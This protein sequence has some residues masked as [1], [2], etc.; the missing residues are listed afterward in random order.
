MKQNTPR[1]A[2]VISI[3]LAFTLL[4]AIYTVL[5]TVDVVFMKDGKETVVCEDVNV[6]SELHLPEGE[7]SYTADGETKAIE[8]AADLRV[9]IGKTVLVNFICFKWDEADNVIT[10]T[11]K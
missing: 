6:F 9:E 3:I 5:G 1:S 7:L 11:Q 8:S 2:G 4:L 10:I